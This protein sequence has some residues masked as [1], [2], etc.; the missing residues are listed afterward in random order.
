MAAGEAGAYDFAFID[1]DQTGYDG[2]YERCLR[3]LRPGGLIVFD[4]M[5]WSGAVAKP[6][7]DA[8]TLALQA[9]ND[10]LH[11]DERVDIALLAVGDGVTLARK[12]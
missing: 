12:R 8:D 7:A 1:A 5:L 9:L 10:K 11:H 2:Y 4:N 6:S 3:L